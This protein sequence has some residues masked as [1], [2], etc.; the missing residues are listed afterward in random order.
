MKHHDAAQ[1][2][3]TISY[4]CQKFREVKSWKIYHFVIEIRVNL[5]GTMFPTCV[6]GINKASWLSQDI[7]FGVAPTQYVRQQNVVR[8][9]TGLIQRKR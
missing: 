9:T 6:S 7:P 5:C 2:T 8:R 3:Y 1:M 4:A